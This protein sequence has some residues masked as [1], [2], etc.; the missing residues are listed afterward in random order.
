[1][2]HDHRVMA[3][4][5]I[6]DVCRFA[7]DVLRSRAPDDVLNLLEDLVRTHQGGFSVL[8]AWQLP[9][10][11][12]DFDF[13]VI[14]RT[15]FFHESVPSTFLPEYLHH[16]R[17]NGSSPTAML[18]RTRITPF[19]LT[20][21]MQQSGGIRWVFDLFFGYAWR[22]CIYVPIG[23]WAV[24]FT[25]RGR[26]SHLTAGE[27][28]TWLML[29]A[30]TASRLESLMRRSRYSRKRYPLER[31]LTPREIAV[32]RE[33]SVGR[34]SE[35]IAAVLG[36]KQATV[37]TLFTRAQHKLGANS[38]THAVAEAIRRRLFD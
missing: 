35:E 1:M 15:V 20:E 16:L 3:A 6:N 13:W 5:F 12:T 23:L 27:R 4:P 32:L 36:I 38:R 11:A 30:V 29:G 21:A 34:T 8:G 2:W 24:V 25:C 31:P 26:L 37:K 33:A 10:R 14:G 17:L 9:R 18:A 22:D 19:T 7:V 28:S